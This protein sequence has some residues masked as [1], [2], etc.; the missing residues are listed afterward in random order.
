MTA[1][2]VNPAAVEQFLSGTLAQVDVAGIERELRNLWKSAVQSDDSN[3]AHSVARACVLNLIL[4]SMDQDAELTAGTLLDEIALQHPCR[5][6]LAISRA[7][8]AMKL[9]AWVS[10]R[11]H[12]AAP[13]SPKQV[14]CEQVTALWE[15]Q[16][17]NELPSVV[18][19]L[20]VPDLPVF[21]YLRT[22]GFDGVALEPFL[23]AVDRLLLDSSRWSIKSTVDF[24]QYLTRKIDRPVVS[25][26]NWARIMAWRHLLANAFDNADTGFS[27]SDLTEIEKVDLEFTPPVSSQVFLL[28][29]WLASR[30]D[31]KPVS[32]A[33]AN[34]DTGQLNFAKGNQAIAVGWT[35]V[36]S[37]VVPEGQ[38]CRVK[39]EMAQGKSL[40]VSAQMR[41]S[42][43]ILT[44][45]CVMP[46][47]GYDGAVA[48][49]GDLSESRLLSQQL[50]ILRRDAVYEQ[51]LYM[52]SRI[53]NLNQRAPT[54]E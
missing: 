6:L 18:I 17:V 48:A 41:E 49:V 42:S 47:R 36:P 45:R 3:D 39:L 35:A 14:C 19:P 44:T 2:A 23:D 52:I 7:S 34:A 10:A 22:P 27:V 12:L 21:L 16:G 51:S 24:C 11:C 30:L 8:E 15:G 31:W 29:A 54:N 40:S 37:D 46:S 4:Y 33:L 26:L 13:G 28:I 38:L 5:A 1:D 43:P 20:L 50:E 9:E 53:C 32:G 25:D